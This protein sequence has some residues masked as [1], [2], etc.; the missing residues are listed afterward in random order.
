GALFSTIEPGYARPT[1]AVGA[2]FVSASVIVGLSTVVSR[3]AEAGRR[4]SRELGQANTQL[5]ELSDHLRDSHA[6]AEEAYAKLRSAQAE[7]VGSAKL[8]TLG[9]LIAGVAHEINT[10]LGALHSNHDTIARALDRLQEILEDEVVDEDE[11]EDVRRIVK[12]IDGVTATNNMAV[13][14]MVK[15]VDSLRTFGRV[16]RSDIDRVDL[17][18]GLE[19]TLAILSHELKDRIDVVKDYGDLPRVECY[20]NQIHQ[21]FMNLIV[22]ATQAIEGRGTLTLRTRPEADEVAVEIADTGVGITEENLARI[23][24]PG[25]TTKGSRMGMGMGLL[26]TSQIIDR[27]GGRI[28]VESE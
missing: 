23:F 27:H 18:E 25:F 16:D 10:P 19:S 8:A 28:A 4:Q 22:N 20:P 2:F 1:Y 7:L 24:D 9:N 5:V 6:E 15:L 26:I 3:Y 12:A 11:L 13:D 17:H 14:R 21:V